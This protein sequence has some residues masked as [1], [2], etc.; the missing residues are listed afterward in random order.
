[1]SDEV[2]ALLREVVARPEDDGVRAV[3][4]DLL[5]HAGDP[6]GELISLQLLAS[7][8][9]RDGDDRIAHLLATHGRGWIG[10][11]EP[12]ARACRFDRGFPSRLELRDGWSA[13]QAAAAAA[14]PVLATIEALVP[15]EARG[16]AYR[17][18]GTSLTMVNLRAIEV[19]DRG[20][21]EVLETTVHPISHVA[22]AR[23]L[24]TD[25][26]YR[27]RD[28]GQ[29][30]PD[31]EDG[32]PDDSS[33]LFRERLWR[34]LSRRQEI[35]ALTVDLETFEMV[36]SQPWFS[37]I[38]SLTIATGSARRGLALWEQLGGRQLTVTQLPNLEPCERQISWDFKIE[39]IAERGSWTARIAGE[40]VLQPMVALEAL[41][42]E[43]TRIEI[44]RSSEQ[45]ARRLREQVERPG[46]EVIEVPVRANNFVWEIR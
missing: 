40:W 6:R 24:I 4:A 27:S 18:F 8:G 45:I 21:L 25:A 14:D 42:P 44:E 28:R 37:R 36:A 29:Y 33:E 10:S 16:P 41:P 26:M 39:L 35:T 15:G 30:Y 46:V 23:V 22:I 20:S 34:A 17:R 7:R 3:L 12:F 38:R 32:G 1:M 19:Y 5:Q 31:A 11:L 9:N 43:V 13:E 2:A